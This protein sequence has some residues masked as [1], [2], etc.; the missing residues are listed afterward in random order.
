MNLLVIMLPM[1]SVI[2]VGII[3]LW[4][5]KYNNNSLLNFIAWLG[6]TVA[7]G[8]S[9]VFAL[10]LL[11]KIMQTEGAISVP[12]FNW[13]V[14]GNFYVNVVLHFDILTVLM[15]CLISFIS[16]LVHFYSYFYIAKEDN[17]ARFQC[18]LSFFTL[19]MIVLVTSDNLL[20]MFVGWEAI[21]LCSYLLIGYWFNKDVANQGAAKAFII[22]KFADMAFVLGIFTSFVLFG[23]INFS[24]IFIVLPSVLNASFD[25]LGVEFS[26]INLIAFLFLIAAFAKS[27]QILFHIWLP[28]AM[29]APTPVSALLH[30]ATMVTAGIFLVVKLSP[31]FQISEFARN[32]ILVVA[33]I[34]AVYGA[35]V[36]CFQDDIKKVIAYS[37][38]SQLGYMF[39]SIGVNA[40]T[41]AM[42]HLFTHAFFKA[43][44][45]LGAGS[46][47]HS[48]M[49]E[50]NIHKMGNL[51]RKMPITYMGM[52]IGFLAL[53]GIPGFS[54]FYSK[55]LI[56]INLYTSETPF[57]LWGFF[58][59]LSTIFFTAFY[60]LRLMILVFHNKENYEGFKPHE[61]SFGILL[62][63]IILAIFSVI[64]GKFLQ[65]DFV[66]ENSTIF[67]KKSLEIAQ[68]VPDVMISK[69][70]ELYSLTLVALAV[71]FTYLLYIR[72]KKTYSKLHSMFPGLHKI[73]YNNFYLDAIYKNWLGESFNKT[74][75]ILGKMDDEVVDKYGPNTLSAIFVRS[76]RLFA[77]WQN[78]SISLYAILMILGL[79]LILTYC[80]FIIGM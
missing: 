22:N 29:E 75:K 55:E 17:L 15:L 3:S 28:D 52:W 51:W 40:Y 14:S 2:F 76:S 73:F 60:S 32:I 25:F 8:L 42:F 26:L 80:F 12:L 5:Y 56:L 68:I 36:A 37:T 77:K 24:E 67:W 30:A 61:S 6:S 38:I 59:G 21:S 47:I 23:S 46:I 16:F 48:M 58:A 62:I 65:N 50:Q 9:T 10:V 33:S 20:Q 79:F 44:L 71:I 43:L 45:F 19:S 41:G 31:I 34:T 4:I 53:I 54:G 57:A 78:N 72:D 69:K 49:G 74:S 11:F 63:L 18:Y 66:G 70:V 64:I 7:I 13:F 27:A 1:L 35:I 39:L